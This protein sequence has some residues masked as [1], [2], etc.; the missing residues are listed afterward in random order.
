MNSDIFARGEARTETP[1]YV[2]RF[3]RLFWLALGQTFLTLVTLGVWRFWMM[4]RMRR[5]Y[6]SSIRIDG[7][8]LEYTGRPL[9]KLIGFL[10][11]VVILAVLLVGLN[12]ALAFVGLSYF[13]CD[14]LALN[15]L[16]VLV[17][18]GFWAQYRARRYIT[19]R[20]RWRG[21]RFGLEPGA[22]GYMF[23]ALGWWLATLVSFGL[24]YPLMQLGLAR[25]TTNRTFFGDL[26]FEQRGGWWPLMKSWLL[27]WLPT[28]V[29]AGYAIYL[30]RQAGIGGVDLSDPDAAAEA[31][32]ADAGAAGFFFLLLIWAGFFFLRHN[33]FSFRY[34]TSHKSLGGVTTFAS[35]LSVWRVI[36]IYLLGSLGLGVVAS[37]ILGLIS[38]V[39]LGA[40]YALLGS[41]DLESLAASVSPQIAP[42]LG[43]AGAVL[44]YLVAFLLM[45]ALTHVFITQPLLRATVASISIENVAAAA[46]ARQRDHDEA[47]EAGG[48]ADALGADVGGAF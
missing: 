17:P 3:W 11:A 28:A 37:L 24:L 30:V 39:G 41:V 26:R 21:I 32:V 8:P 45:I 27:V 47:A 18:L 16:L 35:T 29:W 44:S 46:R 6:W 33:V 14:P 12:L 34:L 10:I 36:G 22:W 19:A 2:G 7:E 9:E 23:H 4:T 43:V 13:E 40:V 25:Y 1:K 42:Y 15:A 31:V 5:Y 38:L 20:T 48:F